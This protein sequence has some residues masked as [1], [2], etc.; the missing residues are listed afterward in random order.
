M[1]T[2]QAC[3][4]GHDKIFSGELRGRRY[5][6]ICRR[7]GYCGWSSEYALP[8]V[9]ADEYLRLRVVYGWATIPHPPRVPTRTSSSVTMRK[10]VELLMLVFVLMLVFAALLMLTEVAGFL[11]PAIALIGSGISLGLFTVCYVYWKR[12]S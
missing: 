7:C 11:T 12:D 8:Q 6:Y 1:T 4:Q 5:A 10:A 9:N 2:D 3:E